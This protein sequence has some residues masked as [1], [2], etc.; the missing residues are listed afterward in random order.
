MLGH[1]PWVVIGLSTWDGRP[2]IRHVRGPIPKVGD[3][4]MFYANKIFVIAIIILK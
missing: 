3:F 4:F 2:W 1:S